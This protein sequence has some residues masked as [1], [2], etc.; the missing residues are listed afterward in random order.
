[1]IST[2]LKLKIQTFREQALS[3]AKILIV[4]HIK[5]DGDAIGSALALRIL[6]KELGRETEVALMDD[7]PE[8]FS[9]LPYFLKIKNDFRPEHFDMVVMADCG[10]WSRTGWFED[11][12]LRIDWPKYLVILDHHHTQD[13][14]PGM[15][16][17][18]ESLSSTAQLVHYIFREWGIE[19]N[20]DAA[21]C[22]M[23]GL[24]TD[25]GSFKHTN[26]TPEVFRIAAELMESGANLNK[27]TQHIYLGRSVASLK[28]W[29]R[30]LDKI[31]Q[32]RALG[33]VISVITTADLEECGAT[34]EDLEGVI[35]LMNTVPDTKAT[36]LLSERGDKL[37]GSV[38]TNDPDVDVSKLAAIFGGGGHIKAAGFNI[39]LDG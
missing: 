28:L 37:K 25:T 31:Q 23:T 10:G 3:A 19:I 16:I 4:T 15:V 6:L 1:M 26:T 38:R 2:D 32:D 18:D 14:S 22:L 17:A 33:I 35:D 7:P 36:F 29:G 20:S 30:T 34:L 8:A 12:E 21:N 5:P 27:I 39:S 11:D 13:Y 24:S 9:F